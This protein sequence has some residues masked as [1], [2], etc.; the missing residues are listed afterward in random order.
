[1]SLPSMILLQA[2]S[3]LKAAAAATSQPVEKLSLIHLL[4]EGGLLMIPLLLC[5]LIMVY[6]FV[7][8]WLVIRKASVV[9]A[10]F[11]TQIREQMVTGNI[12]GARL[13]CRQ[14]PSPLSRIIEKGISRIGR[15]IDVVEKSMENTGKLEVYQLE[16]NISVLSTLAGIAP[17]FGFLGTIAGMIILFFNVQHQGFSLDTIAAGIYTKMVTSAVGLIIGLLSYVGY[18]Y[19]NAQ[20]NKN[21]NRMEA[22]SVEFLDILQEPTR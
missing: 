14:S 3:A 22:A 20:I 5:S 12:A 19:L 4:R 9:A 6:V 17:M 1:M 11:M 13:V 15:P 21:V 7:E 2:D 16:K 8:R 10:N 18:E